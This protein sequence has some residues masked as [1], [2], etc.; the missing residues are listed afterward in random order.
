MSILLPAMTVILIA[1]GALCLFA[2]MSNAERARVSRTA[3]WKDR[4]STREFGVQGI[5]WKA[6]E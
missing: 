6:R 2:A 5:A 4:R 3:T 1:I